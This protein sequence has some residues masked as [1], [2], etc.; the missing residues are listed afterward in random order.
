MVPTNDGTRITVSAAQ[1][2]IDIE[3]AVTV[4]GDAVVV[5]LQRFHKE[6][7]EEIA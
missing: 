3:E 2:D 6:E 7:E 1:T 5:L 4:L